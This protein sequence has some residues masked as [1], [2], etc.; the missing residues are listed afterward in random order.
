MKGLTI[1]F[2]VLMMLTVY[3]SYVFQN[4]KGLF[5]QRK[6]QDVEMSN[7]TKIQRAIEDS[8]DRNATYKKKAKIERLCAQ[9]GVKIKYP[10]YVM[11]GL[12]SSVIC[13]LAFFALLKNEYLA[14]ASLFLGYTIPNQVL[15]FMSNKRL[16][17]LDKQIGSFL[18]IV[19]ERY[20]VTKDFSK[21]LSDTA[22]DLKGS[23]PLYS[24]IVDTL[25]EIELGIPV[26][27]AVKNLSER[28][29]NIYLGRLADYYYLSLQIGTHEA[30]TTLLKQ[31][32]HQYEESRALKTN[33]KV[34]IAGPANEAYLMISFIPGTV[35]YSALTNPEYLPY[36]TTTQIGKI[37]TTFIFAVVIG[38]LWLVSSKIAS[39]IE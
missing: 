34:A 23:E 6:E 11:L 1:S 29:G 21:S 7:I 30:R 36:M 26:T 12:L 16:E 15:T 14:F 37:G 22:E 38:S 10:H 18:Q 33:L 28:T 3:F 13:S 9:A 24:E 17:T 32:Y 25:M 27:T 35:I 19:T 31:A 8:V 5:T 39:P 20:S 4:K 2:C